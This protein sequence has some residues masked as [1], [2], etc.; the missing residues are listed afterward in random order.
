MTNANNKPK[1]GK[2]MEKIVNFL[3]F[4]EIPVQAVIHE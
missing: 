4:S 2:L 3:Q 1:A